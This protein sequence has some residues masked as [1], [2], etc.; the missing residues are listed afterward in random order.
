[1]A[2]SG[3]GE[4]TDINTASF[5]QLKS[6]H[7]I[8]ETLA[9]IICTLWGTD[10]KSLSM[11]ELVDKTKIP[12]ETW[13]IMVV[14]GDITMNVDGDDIRPV[15]PLPFQ[16]SQIDLILARLKEVEE[17]NAKL[18]QDQYFLLNKNQ[19]LVEE[20]EH[21][22]EQCEHFQYRANETD[23]YIEEQKFKTTE[24]EEGKGHYIEAFKRLSQN[25]EEIIDLIKEEE[26]R[27]L[28]SRFPFSLSYVHRMTTY[29]EA[30]LANDVRDMSL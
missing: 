24:D 3:K 28:H 27:S 1:M 29:M 8:R 2:E 7:G 22:C 14:N 9:K 21:I 26:N 18:K 19:Q 13:V 12:R 17:H 25:Y 5:E 23:S 6:I 16:E 4:I 11:D 30:P 10:R 15:K 20:K